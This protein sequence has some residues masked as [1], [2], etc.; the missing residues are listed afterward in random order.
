M[1]TPRRIK[2]EKPEENV[3]G[4]ANNILSFSLL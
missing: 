3:E 1:L 4:K 2:G